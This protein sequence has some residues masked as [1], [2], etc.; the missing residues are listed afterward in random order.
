MLG[1]PTAP[2]F[3]P[4]MRWPCCAAE[5]PQLFYCYTQVSLGGHLGGIYLFLDVDLGKIV[6]LW[7]FGLCFVCVYAT[8]INHW[9]RDWTFFAL[10]ARKLGAQSE[11]QVLQDTL[12]PSEFP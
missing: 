8:D 10:A 3:P 4:G 9:G 7:A 11:A 1:W 5:M 2:H 12:A 6:P